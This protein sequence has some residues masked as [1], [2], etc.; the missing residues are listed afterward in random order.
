MENE[1]LF[2]S[3]YNIAAD[4]VPKEKA[5]QINIYRREPYYE[6]ITLKPIKKVT[7]EWVMNKVNKDKV[8]KS[9]AE[10]FNKLLKDKGFEG[11]NAYP[12]TY[13]IG[14]FIGFGVSIEESK[15]G[16]SKALDQLGINY[17]TEYSDSRYVFRYK[18]S[19]SKE[20]IDEIN[21]IVRKFD[22]GGKLGNVKAYPELVGKFDYWEI[23][24]KDSE[25]N[26]SY[27]Y[28]KKNIGSPNPFNGTEISKEEY[29]R[30][31]K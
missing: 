12:T 11:V 13:G 30:H 21:S 2:I 17:T 18:I 7:F 31:T 29:E 25:N 16:V 8:F 22:K 9:F 28:E 20:N 6:S 10:S 15:K 5:T 23:K 26:I 14:T 19:K 4:E 3:F 27:S 1:G 24:H